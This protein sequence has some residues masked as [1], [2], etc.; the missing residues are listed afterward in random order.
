MLHQ[1]YSV[2]SG[3]KIKKKKL[4]VIPVMVEEEKWVIQ[5]SAC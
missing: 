4:A 2:V 1:L 5:L 3:Y